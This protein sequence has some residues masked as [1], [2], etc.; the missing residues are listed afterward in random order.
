LYRSPSALPTWIGVGT[1]DLFH[2]ECVDYANRLRA[3]GVPTQLRIVPG[4]FHGF[5]VV[6]SQTSV[7]R[8]FRADQLAAMRQPLAS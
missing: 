7:V 6:G 5:D 8:Q 1:A 4:G 3:A 2:D